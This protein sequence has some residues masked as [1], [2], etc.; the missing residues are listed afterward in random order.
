MGPFL[1][2]LLFVLTLGVPGTILHICGLLVTLF[3]TTSAG[4]ADQQP[5]WQA[6]VYFLIPLGAFVMGQTMVVASDVLSGK[7]RVEHDKRRFA[8]RITCRILVLTFGLIWACVMISAISQV[9]HGHL[10][11]ALGFI[12]ASVPIACM[13][14]FCLRRTKRLYDEIDEPAQ[15]G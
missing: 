8:T 2:K 13:T 12:A 1:K 5:S 10:P 3:S 14:W 15:F 7:E 9:V 4:I 11:A 6:L